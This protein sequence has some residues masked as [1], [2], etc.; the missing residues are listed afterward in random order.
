MSDLRGA[1]RFDVE[2]IKLMRLSGMDDMILQMISMI[3]QMQMPAMQEELGEDSDFPLEEYFERVQ[4]RFDVDSLL[5]QMIPI[6]SEIYS[7]EEMMELVAFYETPVG[8]KLSRSLTDIMQEFM[9]EC[10]T[11]VEAIAEK[12]GEDLEETFG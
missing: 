2:V 9:N 4:Q 1:D 5:Y 11:W 12:V 3:L 10:Q 7:K 8:K 6:Y